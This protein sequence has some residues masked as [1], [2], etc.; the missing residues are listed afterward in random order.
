PARSKITCFYPSSKHPFQAL[1]QL[2]IRA[3]CRQC[4]RKVKG[5]MLGF[6][7]I[8]SAVSRF[9]EGAEVLASG[10]PSAPF[11][12]AAT[13]YPPSITLSR[14]CSIVRGVSAVPTLAVAAEATNLIAA[15]SMSSVV[16]D[17]AAWVDRQPSEDRP[18]RL[19]AVVERVPNESRPN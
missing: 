12:G 4:S 11:F 7:L 6:H 5:I 13:E 15:V 3:G 19:G 10:R 14:W 9:W 17:A 16:V 1:V 2:P 18:L 8:K